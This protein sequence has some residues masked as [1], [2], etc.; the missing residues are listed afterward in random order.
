MATRAATLAKPK[1]K[2]KSKPQAKAPTK[3]LKAN[4]KEKVNAKEKEKLKAKVSVSTKSSASGKVSVTKPSL[5]AKPLSSKAISTKSSIITKPASVKAKTKLV[6][7]KDGVGKVV[8][9]KPLSAKPLSAKPLSASAKVATKAPALKASPFKAAIKPAKPLEVKVPEVLE[10]PRDPDEVGGAA[11]FE[12]SA[13]K[14]RRRT[15][16]EIRTRIYWAIFNQSLRRV[17]VFEFDQKIEAEKRVAKLIKA[18]TEHHFIQ[19]IK[20]IVQ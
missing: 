8:S 11:S 10:V 18:T 19:K 13:P 1:A 2:S 15:K 20:A 3:T 7:V 5:K 6:S 12:T 14:P 4:V 9:S 16:G 17:A